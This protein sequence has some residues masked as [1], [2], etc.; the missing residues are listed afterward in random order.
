MK[1]CARG[2][3]DDEQPLS[4]LLSIDSRKGDSFALEQSTIEEIRG[5]NEPPFLNGDGEV[6]ELYGESMSD[7]YG[8][9]ARESLRFDD[10]VIVAAT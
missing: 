9:I 4:G 3:R 1:D 8:V 6:R 10:V 7:S 2:K 5:E